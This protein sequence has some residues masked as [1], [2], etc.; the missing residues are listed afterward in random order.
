MK[1]S[2]EPLSLHFP[3][4]F[5]ACKGR[6]ALTLLRTTQVIKLTSLG[7]ISYRGVWGK[8]LLIGSGGGEQ[9]TPGVQLLDC[10]AQIAE[11]D[12]AELQ[13]RIVVIVQILEVVMRA[14]M[15]PGPVRAC[16]QLSP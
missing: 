12:P 10:P 1:V 2:S 4:C 14:L 11:P 16:H 15:L 5:C 8:L 3:H 13:D 7:T 6:H 9:G